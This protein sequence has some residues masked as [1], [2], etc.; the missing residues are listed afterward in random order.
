MAGKGNVSL[1]SLA[2][3]QL[4]T[5][6]GI[7]IGG[8]GKVDRRKP[9]DLPIWVVGQ[10]IAINQFVSENLVSAGFEIGK[11]KFA[12]RVRSDGLIGLP[13]GASVLDHAGTE[14]DANAL[15]GLAG[16]KKNATGNERFRS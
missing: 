14:L 13:A 10:G 7:E 15:R 3:R 16:G 12:V 9:I 8:I 2:G 1:K 11:T 4:D 5:G 6:S